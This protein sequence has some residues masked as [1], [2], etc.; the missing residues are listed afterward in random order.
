VTHK[1]QSPRLQAMPLKV[2]R[3]DWANFRLHIRQLITLGSFFENYQSKFANYFFLLLKL[4]TEVL[5][6]TKHGLGYIWDDCF[7]NSSG[8]PDATRPR[9]QGIPRTFHTLAD[10]V[11]FT[12]LTDIDFKSGNI[13]GKF[14]LCVSPFFLSSL[15]LIVSDCLSFRYQS[16]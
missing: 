9:H 5:I 6:L 11:W 4:Y 14:Q 15:G 7:I 10:C 2:T 13:L 3:P 16:Q 1:L 8:H 12:F